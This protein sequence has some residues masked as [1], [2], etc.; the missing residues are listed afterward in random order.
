[1][2]PLAN[3]LL[4]GGDAAALL[5]GVAILLDKGD[6]PRA[7]LD[8]INAAILLGPDRPQN[9]FTRSLILMSLGLDAHALDDA[10]ALAAAEPDRGRFLQ[11]YAQVLFPDFDFWPGREAP[12]TTYDGLPDKPAQDLPAIQRVVQKYATR[13]DKVRERLAAFTKE[14]VSPHWRIPS[15]EGLLPDGRVELDQ[16]EL[17]QEDSEESISI[18]ETVD[19]DGP[20]TYLMRLARADWQALC[21]L[22]WSC[23]LS[24]VAMPKKILPPKTFG[25]AAG[26]SAQRLWRCRDRRVTGGEGAKS[27]GVKTFQWEGI[28]IDTLEPPLVPIAEAQYAEMQAMFN[29]LTN[30]SHLSPW[31]DNLRGS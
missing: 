29:W 4:R 5:R 20:I 1:F 27:Q 17:E 13:L 14:G 11:R 26:M 24:D 2:A 22:C 16:A 7:A 10:Q 6:R 23:G 30:T 21:W 25:K 18:D 28:D 9:L 15:L 12:E 19:V 31:Q 3:A 8:Y